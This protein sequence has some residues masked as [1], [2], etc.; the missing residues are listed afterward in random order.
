MAMERGQPA[1]RQLQLLLELLRGLVGCNP[2]RLPNGKSKAKQAKVSMQ[3][4]A[5]KAQHAKLY[6]LHL[7]RN[8]GQADFRMQRLARNAQHV[9]LIVQMS[10]HNARQARPT[11]QS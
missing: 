3:S 9:K 8:S 2:L 4:S 7:G 5:R 1:Q 6:A 10:A 11:M